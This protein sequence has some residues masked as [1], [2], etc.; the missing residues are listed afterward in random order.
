MSI[1]KMRFDE[2][3]NERLLN[4]QWDEAIAR[5]VLSRIKKRNRLYIACGSMAALILLVV[6]VALWQDS[7]HKDSAYSFIHAQANGVFTNVFPDAQSTDLTYSY[8]DEHVTHIIDTA[9]LER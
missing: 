1:S 7:Q 4:S 5:A 6:G 3:I 2:A 8:V 9:L